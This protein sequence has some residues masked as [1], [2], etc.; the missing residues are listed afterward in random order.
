VPFYKEE[1]GIKANDA[2]S[3]GPFIGKGC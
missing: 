2:A 3:C 1:K